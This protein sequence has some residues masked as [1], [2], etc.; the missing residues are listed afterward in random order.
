MAFKLR[1]YQQAAIDS[2]EVHFK[3]GIASGIFHLF[4][5]AGKSLITHELVNQLFHPE[6]GY[7]TLV[8]GGINRELVN[9][10]FAGFRK[11][12]PY[13]KMEI[14]VGD[15]YA[16]GIGIV[17]GN[18]NDVKARVIVASVQTLVDKS[19]AI[20]QQAVESKPITADDV[21][22]DY[23]G[24]IRKTKTSK[25]RF[26]VS[27]RFDQILANGGPIHLWVHDEA[28]H[29]PADGSLLLL[30][31][32]NQ[33]YKLLGIDEVKLVGNTATP[34]RMDGRAMANAFQK[35]FISRD[36]RWGQDQGFLCPFASPITMRVDDEKIF[37]DVTN[38]T[39]MVVKAWREKCQNEDGTHRPTF[40]YTGPIGST[41]SGVDAS[42]LL[43][44]AFNEAGVPA[45][46]LDGEKC[47]GPDGEEIPAKDRGKI[48]NAY[49]R[50]EIKV[51][52][53]YGVLIEGVDLPPTS[54]I[55]LGRPMNEV[56]LT[57]VI[58][59]MLRLFD[60]DA[61]LP[62]KDDA[63][64]IDMT[65]KPLVTTSIGSLTGYMIDPTTQQ[66]VEGQSDESL[67]EEVASLYVYKQEEVVEFIQMGQ[68][69]YPPEEYIA[70]V[71][72]CVAA[73][74]DLSKRERAMAKMLIK[75]FGEDTILEGDTR[76]YT[77]QGVVHGK[78]TSYDTAKIVA[79]SS[80]DWHV[81][82]YTAAMSL[83]VSGSD[84]LLILPPDWGLNDTVKRLLE[85]AVHRMTGGISGNRVIDES[86]RE[87]LAS[88]VEL[89]EF[90]QDMASNFTLWHID[91]TDLKRP[92]SASEN[93]GWV[94]ISP[95]LDELEGEA[96][97]YTH[98]TISY[99][100]AL[101][102]KRQAWKATTRHGQFVEATTKKAPIISK[103]EA[104]RLINHLTV[105]QPVK[106]VLKRL[107]NVIEHLEG[108]NNE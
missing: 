82:T 73:H 63:L 37:T 74:S 67:A 34:V 42:I 55:M 102:G 75:Y 66:Y 87:E 47:I 48:F 18:V 72:K 6:E 19:D 77:G 11:Q 16:P 29:L 15:T 78:D 65:G 83:S 62:K 14:P 41:I 13:L 90:T 21:T 64:L 40:V 43:A 2:A 59:R 1:G 51:L 31:R 86:T 104:A 92:R 106:A 38:W 27:P 25:R 17:M 85:C 60:G 12:L 70:F 23:Q 84:S 45:A 32:L 107:T 54:A 80:N 89:L 61:S 20:E 28:H 56:M 100:R 94:A 4:T 101:M 95:A 39:E 69:T 79:R 36:F 33:L 71:H 88:I 97:R 9:Q 24:N 99:D 58:G 8:V 108:T 91:T 30:H 46:H 81:D 10:M 44:E 98:A 105:L 68:S 96:I 49:L 93:G 5:G 50:G 57:Q 7:R 26:L 3:R 35:I 53:N 76:Q 52:T 22:V 103:G